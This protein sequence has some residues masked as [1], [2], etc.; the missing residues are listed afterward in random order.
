MI[1]LVGHREVRDIRQQVARI[2]RDLDEP[3]PPL[4]L[5]LVRELL[6]LDRSYY[7]IANPG[8][9][10]EVAHRVKVAGKQIVARPTLL[11]DVIKKANLSALWIPDSK[12]ILIDETVPEAKHRWMEAHEIGHSIIPWHQEFLFGDNEQT[13]DP[14]CHATI[15]AEA[16]FGASRL[17]FMQ[18]RFGLEAREMDLSFKSVQ[19]LKNRYGNTLTSTFWRFV[20]DRNPAHAAFGVVGVHPKYPDIGKQA[21]GT[22]YRYF[23][24]SQRFREQFSRVDP[25]HVKQI[26]ERHASWKKSGPIIDATDILVDNNGK[27][28]EFKIEGFSNKYDLLTMG[29]LLK[30]HAETVSVA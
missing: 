17:L 27:A 8:F 12:R 24:R 4:Q 3:E 30:E 16:N 10:A 1:E 19:M 2:L 15:E 28:Y 9:L 18:D 23:I 13:L 29:F 21:D 7:N 14:Q 20:E 5:E 22:A 6:K 26:I 25:D 11:I